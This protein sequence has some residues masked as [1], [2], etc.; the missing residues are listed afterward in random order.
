MTEDESRETVEIL[1]HYM[2]PRESRAFAL[3]MWQR[4]GEKT[5]NPSVRD[6]LESILKLAEQDTSPPVPPGVYAKWLS[7]FAVHW[8]VALA[9]AVSAVVVVF[10]ALTP[11]SIPEWSIA[12]PVVTFVVWTIFSRIY[13][14]PLTRMENKIRIK[15]GLLPMKSFLKFYL[16]GPLRGAWHP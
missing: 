6:T 10:C 12:F 3:A 4:I 2:S 13:D 5:N 14:C 7:V 16:I 8:F 11:Y 1:S 9:N 15:Y